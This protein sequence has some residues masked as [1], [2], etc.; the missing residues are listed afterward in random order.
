M[1]L[2]PVKV[3]LLPPELVPYAL[4][5]DTFQN[6]TRVTLQWPPLGIGG[7]GT[8]VAAQDAH[9]A[10]LA[11]KII[12]A[13]T[14]A[15]RDQVRQEAAILKQVQHAALLCGQGVLWQKHYPHV[16]VFFLAMELVEGQTLAAYLD[17]NGTLDEAT[18]LEWT[19]AIAEGLEAIH[20][21]KVIHRDVKPDNIILAQLGRRYQPVL[22]D[23]GIAKVGNHTERGAKA[24]TDGYAP[25]EQYSG[26]TDQRSDI[27]ALGATLFEMVTGRTPPKATK[28]DM[29][30]VLEPRQFNARISA[31]LEVVI[32]LATAC[33]PDQRFPTMGALLDALR[34]VESRDWA[35][36]STVLQAL[37]LVKKTNNQAQPVS[38]S[39]ASSAPQ[40]PPL[41]LK[42]ATPKL[43][44]V[45][46]AAAPA[47]VSR[48]KGSKHSAC[49][50]CR[51]P[52]RAGEAFCPECGFA[53]V[54]D[55]STG[56]SVSAS[57][58]VAAAPLHYPDATLEFHFWEVLTGRPIVLGQ[59]PL[60]RAGFVV[61]LLLYICWF[62]WGVLAGGCLW[63]AIS[64]EAWHFDLVF[65]GMDIWALYFVLRLQHTVIYRKTQGSKGQVVF[66]CLASLLLLAGIGVF[67][68]GV[69]PFMPWPLP[70]SRPWFAALV[71]G[72][73]SL[74]AYPCIKVWLS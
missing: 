58:G 14:D 10:D 65:G 47:P 3:K 52:L 60:S 24:A 36:L 48:P 61:L 40:L 27:Y 62:G 25:P 2:D 23:Y 35:A 71:A 37:G 63:W 21:Q 6:V 46:P 67:F 13:D 74:A 49:P 20:R 64:G 1:V 31:E 38:V 15:L 34:L 53:L 11:I 4:D 56:G 68:A 73:V 42:K 66:Q 18:A 44:P 28:R 59:Y 69:V 45:A 54:P 43:T 9:G 12:L 41:P 17:A 55:V 26:G 30:A 57:G 22:V 8:V 51:E 16:D 32:Q 29:K 7:G 70:L 72:A 19:I 33:D 50:L 39:G 5:I